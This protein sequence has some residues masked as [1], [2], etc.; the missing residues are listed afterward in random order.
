MKPKRYICG[1]YYD[2]QTLAN[3]EINPEFVLQLLSEK[4]YRLVDLLGKKSGKYIDKIQ[5]LEKR[6]ELMEWND[7]LVLKNCLAVMKM[8]VIDSFDA[9][10][11]KCFLCDVVSYKNINEGNP[12][13]LD[14]LR[15]HNIIR[16]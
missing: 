2:T 3:I 8:K 15:K 13:M 14:T 6:K 10:D 12:L 4:Q 7:F 16:A 9:G 5:R 1:I 11:H